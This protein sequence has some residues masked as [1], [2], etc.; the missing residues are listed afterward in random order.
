MIERIKRYLTMEVPEMVLVEV[1]PVFQ[2]ERICKERARRI[3]YWR[4]FN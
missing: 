2:I 4:K 3:S 1:G